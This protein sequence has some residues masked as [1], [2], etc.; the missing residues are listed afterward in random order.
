MRVFRGDR[1]AALLRC[2]RGCPAIA[3]TLPHSAGAAVARRRGR[4][5]A[6]RPLR[7]RSLVGNRRVPT[8]R[9]S[10]SRRRSVTLTATSPLVTATRPR[11]CR[12]TG[13]TARLL[14]FRMQSPG[15]LRPRRRR[16]PDRHRLAHVAGAP[17]SRVGATAFAER[18]GARTSMLVC[19]AS[20]R[21]TTTAV[22][23]RRGALFGGTGLC[24][25]SLELCSSS[26]WVGR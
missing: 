13:R 26:V 6:G 4:A 2:W 17:M 9:R 11:R 19:R 16:H 23:W 12:S 18:R 22:S 1:S 14:R 20:R 7:V 10:C 21:S 25:R 5:A 24:R 8:A 15:G 3:R